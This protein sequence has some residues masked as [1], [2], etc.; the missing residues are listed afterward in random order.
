[1][2]II[3]I[4]AATSIILAG[5]VFL[6]C[7]SK[8]RLLEERLNRAEKQLEG[9]RLNLEKAGK[10]TDRIPDLTARIKQ[11]QDEAAKL[12]AELDGSKSDR[13]AALKEKDKALKIIS[14]CMKTM[15]SY[16][17]EKQRSRKKIRN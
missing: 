15:P 1:M 14:S 12:K 3:S 11:S 6:G 4:I 16:R 5:T 7:D 9:V 17:Q 13:E 8:S 2:R 10:E